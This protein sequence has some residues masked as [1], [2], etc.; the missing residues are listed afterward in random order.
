MSSAAEPDIYARLGVSRVINAAGKLTALGGSVLHDEVIAAMN[1]A[2]RSHVELATLRRAAGAEIARLLEAEAACV[3]AGAAAGI[4]V[5]V[6]A[7]I[8]GTDQAAVWRLPLTGGRANEVLLQTGHWV[9]FGA[10]VEQMVR[11]AGGVPVAV[12]WSNSTPAAAFRAALSERTAA[13]LFVQSH[14]A[15][16][17]GM[18]SLAECLTLCRERGVP[19]IVDAAAEEDPFTALRAGADLVIFSGAKA[20]EGPTTGIVAGR[21]ALIEACELQ[22]TGIAR[23][24]KVGKEDIAGL[25][26]ALARYV[27]AWRDGD[28]AAAA[29]R[30]R[31][32]DTLFVALRELPH[33]LVSVEPD[34]AGRAID[35]VALQP[36][37]DELGFNAMQLADA[38]SNGNPS[39]RIRPHHL[40]RG[41]VLLDPRALSEDEAQTVIESIRRAYAHLSGV[42]GKR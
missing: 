38:L 17:K 14:H 21:R 26:V 24:M 30:R 13:C 32:V 12:G 11:M 25:V 35:R 3:V 41:A 2:A 6:G 8:A 28:A 23:T 9:N 22:H 37:A 34:E 16:Q 7:V 18:L 29:H 40:A 42:S 15:V 39:V 19:V 31:I 36:C 4:A 33:T 5:A 20:F 10:P 1:A 27:S